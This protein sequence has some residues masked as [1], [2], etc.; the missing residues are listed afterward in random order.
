MRDAPPL[1]PRWYVIGTRAINAALLLVGIGAAV[2]VALAV[3]RII[4][5]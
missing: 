5:Q 3:T 4:E 2:V 1:L